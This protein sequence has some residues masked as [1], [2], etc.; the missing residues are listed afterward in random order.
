MKEGAPTIPRPTKEEI[1]SF[2]EEARKL[3]DRTWAAQEPLVKRGDYH[4]KW[5]EGKHFLL[6]GATGPGLGGAL[7][8]AL[9]N[10]LGDFGSL[11]IVARDLTRSIGYETGAAMQKRAEEA[12]FGNRFHWL[13]DGMALEGEV[14]GKIIS[15]LKE[16]RANRVVYIN[17]VAAANSG[18][19]PGH[20]PVFV[21]DVD[22][23]GLFQWQLSPLNERSIEATKFIMG[24][25]AVQFPQEL[26]GADIRVEATAFADW[27][28]SLDRASR[29]S[30]A[31]EYGRQGAY[32][33]SLYLPKD[34]IQE[35]AASAYGSGKVVIDCFFPVMRTRAL[36]FIPGGTTMA[37][38][39]EKLMKRE[40]VRR[41]DIPELALAM[42]DRLGKAIHEGYDNPFPRLDSHEAPFDLW[43]YE[44]VKRLNVNENSDFYFKKWV[45]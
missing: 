27:R 43:F 9:L 2:P 32:S 24:T 12:G 3:L 28:G 5:L 26:E 33:T 8:T 14:F 29:D 35:A 15:L 38:V 18:L 42:L 41:I 16:A 10:L 40:G 17:T 44:V 23:E 31:P 21:K 20:P 22:E 34:I 1:D 25:M 45:D 7:A 36:A 19:L 39:F 37:A 13:N 11:T 6:A 30:A 4:L